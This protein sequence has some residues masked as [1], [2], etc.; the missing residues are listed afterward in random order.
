MQRW[1][2]Q[3]P[4]D[5]AIPAEPIRCLGRVLWGKQK[6][7]L[8]SVWVC[9]DRFLPFTRDVAVLIIFPSDARA[10]RDAVS[11]VPPRC[12][13]QSS[14][15]T[16]TPQI[17]R[18]SP[19]RPPRCTLISSV[20]YSATWTLLTRTNSSRS[21]SRALPTLSIWYPG[22]AC[23]EPPSAHLR[24]DLFPRSSRQILSRSPR[25]RWHRSAY[26]SLRLLR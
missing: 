10:R 16:I 24:V 3:A 13:A 9:I 1:A 8:K 22:C 7:G 19:Q 15:V 21:A 11:Y 4:P 5:V 14:V 12:T 25:R 20:V 26:A 18:I 23:T 2:E 17:E 6:R